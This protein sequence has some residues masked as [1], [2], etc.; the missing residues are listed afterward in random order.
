MSAHSL[1][2]LYIAASLASADDAGAAERANAVIRMQDNEVAHQLFFGMAPVRRPVE[3]IVGLDEHGIKAIVAMLPAPL[4]SAI[5]AAAERANAISGP[6][7][8]PETYFD[9]FVFSFV[10]ELGKHAGIKRCPVGGPDSI[11]AQAYGEAVCRYMSQLVGRGRAYEMHSADSDAFHL[12]CFVALLAGME[13]SGRTPD[14][15]L[16]QR[17]YAS[18]VKQQPAANAA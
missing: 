16:W 5:K 11:S 4:R 12:P 10:D 13:M 6:A 7:I 9:E 2:I 17:Y 18:L 15:P 1:G 14:F 3:K 8:A